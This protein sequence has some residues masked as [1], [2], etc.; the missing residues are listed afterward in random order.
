MEQKKTAEALDVLNDIITIRMSQV[1][2]DLIH[3]DTSII[4]SII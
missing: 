2:D 4:S 3:E 1:S